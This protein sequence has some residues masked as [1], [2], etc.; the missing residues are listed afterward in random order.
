VHDEV[1]ELV[2][3]DPDRVVTPAV[4]PDMNVSVPRTPSPAVMSARVAD[5]DAD[6]P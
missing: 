3:K 6:S 4:A 2:D 1:G 5:R